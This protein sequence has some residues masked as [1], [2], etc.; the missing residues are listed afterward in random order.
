MRKY[1]CTCAHR[2]IY[3][4]ISQK[5]ASKNKRA[6]VFEQYKHLKQISE[7]ALRRFIAFLKASARDFLIGRE[8]DAGSGPVRCVS[9]EQLRE[10]KA[11]CS[12]CPCGLHQSNLA[13]G[14]FAKGFYLPLLTAQ[15]GHAS[16]I[17]TGNFW[18]RCLLM[19][20]ELVDSDCISIHHRAPSAKEIAMA[21]LVMT[22]FSPVAR[23]KAD[24]CTEH[25]HRVRAAEAQWKA[26]WVAMFN[27]GV[28]FNSH[29]GRCTII[30]CCGPH[31]QCEG[32]AH[33]RARIKKCLLKVVC[34][35]HTL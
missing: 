4:Y 33:T 27:G 16:L 32:Q 26:E 1:I 10:V 19:M 21:K 24:A 13:V 14:R 29:I 20:D 2:N 6:Y 7:A 34:W 31:C 18:L 5:V 15:H 11:L 23:L 8:T 25:R 3:T 17:Q 28:H 12:W 30:H 35:L 9:F 22:W